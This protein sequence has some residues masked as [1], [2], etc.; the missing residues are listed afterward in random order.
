[1]SASVK[2]RQKLLKSEGQVCVWI[3]W[4][5]VIYSD[6]PSDSLE[7]AAFAVTQIVGLG[8]DLKL[9]I[10]DSHTVDANVGNVEP[11]RVCGCF[12]HHEI[13]HVRT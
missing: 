7:S 4:L 8:L 3:A 13:I 10:T 9:I 11:C 1:M 12:A 6:L 5:G 2:M